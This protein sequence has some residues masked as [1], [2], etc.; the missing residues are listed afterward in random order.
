MRGPPTDFTYNKSWEQI[1]DKLYQLE[2]E[3][4]EHLDKLQSSKNKK[5]KMWH[6]RQFKALEGA[7]VALRWVLGDRRADPSKGME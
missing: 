1:E 7:V 2:R 3:Q 6:A 5:Q 4:Q